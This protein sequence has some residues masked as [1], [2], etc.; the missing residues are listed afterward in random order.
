MKNLESLPTAYRPK[1]FDHVVGQQT[2]VKVLRSMIQQGTLPQQVLFSGPSGT[3]KTTLARLAAAGLLCDTDMGERESSNPCQSCDACRD[4]LG[5]SS[6]HPDVMEMDAASNGRVDEIRELANVVQLAPQRANWRVVIIDEAHGLS[7]PGG[8][9]FLKLL[10][11]PPPHVI[12]FLATTDPEKMLLTNRSRVSELPLQRPSAGEV[13]QNL[14]RVAADKNWNLTDQLATAVVES[15]DPALGV[16]GSLMTL[17]KIAPLLDAGETEPEEAFNLLGAATPTAVKNLHQAY[18][19]GDTKTAL[20]TAEE[21]T[22]GTSAAVVINA[23]LRI[24]QKDKRAAANN[25]NLESLNSLLEDESI[26]INARLNQLPLD[27]A[28]LK[29]ALNHTGGASSPHPAGEPA[30]PV[31]RFDQFK[32]EVREASGDT[33]GILDDHCDLELYNQNEV[34]ITA[35]Q[36]TLNQL[37]AQPHGQVLVQAMKETGTKLVPRAR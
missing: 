16:R 10:E 17:Q 32:Q 13:A 30:K 28:A 12:F 25:Q 24:I 33:W 37:R 36:E 5:L 9:A 15:T 35:S 7:G 20:A 14:Q 19:S 29:L 31:G 26:L 4:I 3:G 11:E 22:N 23:L 34:V 21:A 1:S 27:H 6:R 8:Q 18:T 2:V